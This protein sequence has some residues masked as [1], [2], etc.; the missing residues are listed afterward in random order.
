MGLETFLSITAVRLCNFGPTAGW[1]KFRQRGIYPDRGHARRGW[2]AEEGNG[3]ILSM[4]YIFGKFVV[5]GSS[6]VKNLTQE[7]GDFQAFI[8]KH[9]KFLSYMLFEP[10]VRPPI[11][12]AHCSAEFVGSI[13]M[14]RSSPLSIFSIS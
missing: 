12:E 2:I 9:Y 5:A 1:L 8:H 4:N 11:G 3:P 6:I 10:G 14:T 7:I 13:C